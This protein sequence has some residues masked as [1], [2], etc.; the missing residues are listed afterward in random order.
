MCKN[1]FLGQY[2]L[3]VQ[4]K[5]ETSY[6]SI[7]PCP[8][9]IQILISALS[10]CDHTS[11][12]DLNNGF[13]VHSILRSFHL[14]V[15]KNISLIM[16]D[17][18]CSNRSDRCI[19]VAKPYATIPCIGSVMALCGFSPVVCYSC[20]KLVSPPLNREKGRAFIGEAG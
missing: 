13:H 4:N 9:L 14:L 12:S 16:Q 20:H 8:A 10:T 17:F 11:N 15:E 3:T 1:G 5:G 18:V 7:L 19:I 6:T 2:T